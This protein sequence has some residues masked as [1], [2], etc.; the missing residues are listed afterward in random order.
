MKHPDRFEQ[1]VAQEQAKHHRALLAVE[2]IGLLR[3]QHAAYVRMVKR[4]NNWKVRP[5]KGYCIGQHNID[6]ISR[7]GLLAAFAKY[8]RGTR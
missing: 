5:I 1:A 3:R 4:Q 2:M 7:D 6:W 8:K